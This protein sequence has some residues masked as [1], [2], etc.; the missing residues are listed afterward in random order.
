MVKNA[1]SGFVARHVMAGGSAALPAVGEQAPDFTMIS[2]EDKKVSLNDFRGQ[3]VVLYFYPKDFTPGCTIEAHNF[4]RDMEKFRARNAAVLGVSVDT[5]QSHKDFC[6]KE[7]LNF[8]LL[9]DAD[10]TASKAYGS[11]MALGPLSVSARNTFIVD[12]SGKIAKVFQG[13]KPAR[14]CEEVLAALDELQ[15]KPVK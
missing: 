8:L 3:W 1:R 6:A 14:H 13:V 2:H 5:A 15:K 9:S 10:R 11:L 7:G 12:P 4:E